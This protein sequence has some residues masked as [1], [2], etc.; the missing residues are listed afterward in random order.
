M[1]GIYT[2]FDNTNDFEEGLATSAAAD[3]RSF[4]LR[5]LGVFGIYPYIMCDTITSD[6]VI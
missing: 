1:S 6:E 3:I 5:D 4:F 2:I